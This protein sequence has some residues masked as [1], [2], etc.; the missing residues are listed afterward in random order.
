MLSIMILCAFPGIAGAAV[1]ATFYQDTGFGGPAVSLA[2]GNYTTA[3]LAAAGIPNNWASSV[4]VPAGYTVEIYDNDNF[5]GLKW[6]FTADNSDFVVAGCNDVMSS[7]K[8]YPG[9][10][11]TNQIRVACVG[12]SDTSSPTGYGTPNYPYYLAQMLGGDYTVLNFGASG[13]TML[14]RGNA[15]YWNTQQYIDSSNS[16][17]DIVII[18]LGSNDSK[19]YNWVYQNE[20]APDYREMIDHYRNLPSHPKVYINTLLTVYGAGN[21]DIT[22]PIVTGQICPLIR[23]IGMEK[24]CQV[25]DVNSATKNMPQ[26]FPDNIH[27]NSAGAQVVAQTVYNGLNLA[28]TDAFSQIEAENYNNI[29]G[30]VRAE[31]C[32]EGGQDLGYTSTGDCAAYYKVDFGSGAGQFQARIAGLS[33]S[34]KIHIKLDNTAAPDIGVINGV[35]TGDW[36]S[37]TTAS[38][39]IGNVSG[40]HDVYLVFDTGINLNWFKFAGSATG[41]ESI[42]YE[43]ENAVVANGAVVGDDSA[44]SGGKCIQNMHIANASCQIDNINGNTGGS[45]IL[46]INYASNETSSIT[47][48]VN[49]ISAGSL[50]CPATG[51]WSTFTGSVQKAITLNSGANNTIKIVGGNGGVNLDYITIQ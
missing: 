14:K 41:G 23:Q 44:A 30:T 10:P 48:Y 22:D 4:R 38:C 51:G 33:T 2:P 18:M 9:A 16:S 1:T 6:V 35:N 31:A 15:P 36:Q 50:S 27:P 29:K 20:Y 40:V 45:K 3:Q 46:T 39:N 37:Y 34:G 12:A 7:V 26:N 19:P 21:F 49:G 47:V 5:G 32:G 42:K 11:T 43:A 8:F 25:I 24:G 17:P 13:T 28:S